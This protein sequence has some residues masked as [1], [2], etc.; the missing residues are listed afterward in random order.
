MRLAEDHIPQTWGR[1]LLGLDLLKIMFL[2]VRGEG[3]GF[4]V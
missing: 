2:G 3:L 1:G 4:K